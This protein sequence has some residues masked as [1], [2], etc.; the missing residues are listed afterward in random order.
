MLAQ[1]APDADAVL[2]FSHL[3]MWP[4]TRGR[5]REILD[6][7]G[8]LEILHRHDVDVYASGHHHGFFA[9][10][11]ETGLLH[12]SVGALGGN[13]RPV[14][15]AAEKQAH[16]YTVLNFG[17]GAFCLRALQGP[18]FTGF[19][20]TDSLPAGLEGPL[21]RLQRV[22]PGRLACRP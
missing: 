20:G 7:P 21:G 5:E 19:I 8:L 13:V 15:G 3:P 10:T 12:L 14:L 11:D 22:E 18:D 2:V 9:G 17:D 16:S 6:D 4:V 1:H